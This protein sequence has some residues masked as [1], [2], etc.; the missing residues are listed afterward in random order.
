M[1]E[2]HIPTASETTAGEKRDIDQV[3]DSNF[4]SD[5]QLEKPME[6][7]EAF[8][9]TSGG[10]ESISAELF[11]SSAAQ[12]SENKAE[13][14]KAGESLE[15]TNIADETVSEVDQTIEQVNFEKDDAPI[16]E[17]LNYT[18]K[19]I[20]ISQVV[21]EE[22]DD[23]NDAFNALKRDEIDALH[24][25]SIKE[26][27]KEETKEPPETPMDTDEPAT[28]KEIASEVSPS[29]PAKETPQD[30]NETSENPE[31]VEQ[32]SSEQTEKTTVDK[33]TGD[34]DDVQEIET[35]TEADSGE[36]TAEKSPGSSE[37]AEERRQSVDM[38]ESVQSPGEQSE[39]PDEDEE[40]ETTNEGNYIQI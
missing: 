34:D 15:E 27:V 31:T 21:M 23:S 25:E 37:I 7:D 28:E 30:E 22:H 18:E 38:D 26:E 14:E 16:D 4:A 20:N 33:G 40:T 5:N 29:S 12:V 11:E 24:E 35:Q 36:V 8:P 1:D 13:D 9:S 6:V 10:G 3:L 17:T 39:K 2:P 32:T 19:S